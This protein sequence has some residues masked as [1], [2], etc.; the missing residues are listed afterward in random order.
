MGIVLN[1]TNYNNEKNIEENR[2]ITFARKLVFVLFL[3]S[4]LSTSIS[5]A[6]LNQEIWRST[7]DKSIEEIELENNNNKKAETNCE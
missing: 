3:R 5:L 4:V 6:V 7:S 2:Q 1:R